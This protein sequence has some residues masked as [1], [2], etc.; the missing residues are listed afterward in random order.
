M[1]LELT[2]P[3]LKA[4]RARQLNPQLILEIEGV[5]T[6]YGAVKILKYI[7]IG[8]PGL[9]IDSSW[10]IGGL[11]A[12]EDQQSL[13]TFQGTSTSID[14]Q[15][16][17]DQGQ[18]TSV[19]SL[20]V[21]L[22]DK[23]E[24]ISELITPGQVV[25]EIL[26]K[27]AKVYLGFQNT[28]FPEDYLIIFRGIISDV[29]SKAGSVNLTIDHPD[30]K[31]RQQ[32]YKVATCKLLSDIT[33]S[34]TTIPVD[35]T[36]GYLLPTAGP[37]GTL[38]P[39]FTAFVQIGD[40]IIQYTGTTANSFTGCTRGALGT[41]LAA[42]TADDDV[43]AYYRIQDD[44][45]TMAL[46]LMLSGAH[47]AFATGV[48][49]QSVNWTSP[50]DHFPNA[51]FFRNVD[52]ETEYGL[53]P[54]DYVSTTGSAYPENNLTGEVIQEIQSNNDGSFII[55]SSDLAMT[56]ETDATL[57][58]SFRSKYDTLPEGLG[59]SPDEVDVA[60]H[61]RLRKQFLS[62]MEY[63]F[64]IK[65]TI[66]AKAFIE[67]EIYM[68][69]AAYS[70]PR[71]SKSSVG[72]SISPIPGSNT[73][74][75]DRDSIT[76]PAKLAVRRAIGKN[77]FNGIIYKMDQRVLSDDFRAGI[78]I[79][80]ATSLNAIPVGVRALTIESRGLR[81]ASGGASLAQ[82]QGAR[83][84]K[85]YEMGAEM[86]ESVELLLKDGFTVEIGDVILL[87]SDG[88]KLTNTKTGTRERFQRL[89]EV[90][91][92]KM[93]THT[94]K[95]VVSL[96]DTKFNTSKHYGLISPSSKIGAVYSAQEFKIEQSFNSDFGKDEF[97]KWNKY[98]QPFVKI[99]AADFSVV[100]IAQVESFN[101][102][103]VRLVAPL[104][105]L[106]A[107]GQF[108]ELAPYDLQADEIKLVYVFLSDGPFPDGRD[109]YAMV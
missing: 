14:Q 64:F 35:T 79:T 106:P 96:L 46:K 86:L 81:T 94:G 2:L 48:A 65:D 3:A 61:E 80:S 9:Y 13:I 102:N 26:G 52:V 32:I 47:G 82:S 49:A 19:S 4:S 38:D 22:V 71:K 75:L 76:N 62:G 84:L 33:N 5:S 57:L 27:K 77:F 25:D 1:S 60:E 54:G 95:V 83:K 85:R 101:G 42:H 28:G 56:D 12:L 50:T 91:N 92:K 39:A 58:V 11:N 70:L 68:P 63:D 30:T 97:R 15:I 34:D 8:D 104:A 93:D 44:A 24:L 108:M 43:K 89:F 105:T 78:V 36:F 98:K 17:I 69:A 72:Y 51:V 87:D 100:Q 103:R 99:R 20:T 31:K 66:D 10:L 107:A 29:V 7:R 53:V 90:I 23:N 109:Q 16:N 59:M 41:T 88:L 21:G 37:D 45:M 55:F 73:K 6:R 67:K 18:G 40:E 74:I